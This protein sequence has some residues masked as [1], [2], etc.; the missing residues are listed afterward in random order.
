MPIE[1]VSIQGLW[2]VFR[3]IPTL[4]AFL[5][6][7]YFTADRLAGLVYVD[8]NP[9]NESARV[10]LGCIATFQLHLQVINLSPFELEL[11][12]ANFL[13][14]CGGVRLD[15]AILKKERIASGASASLFISGAI[16][17]G[18]AN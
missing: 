8:V 1:L 2:P 16:P 12:R 5:T 17:D 18:H 14:W 7:R 3:R 11:D 10:D 4:A 15:A 9:R 13:F 6:R